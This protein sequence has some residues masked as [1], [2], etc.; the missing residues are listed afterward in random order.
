SLQSSRF[1]KVIRARNERGAVVVKLFVKQDN[2]V[3]YTKYIRR[4]RDINSRLKGVHNA[5]GFE[6]VID[7]DRLVAVVRQYH[8]SSLY[9]RISTR[10]FLS[11][12]EK[13]WISF[14]L[15]AGLADAHALGV[16]HGDIKTENVLVT[17]WCWALLAD[18][19]SFKPTFLPQD[20]PAAFAFFFDTSGRRTCCVAPERFY[21]PQTDKQT[22]AA[23]LVSETDEFREGDLTPAMDI[24]SLGCV[25]AELF[26]ESHALFSFAQLLA[27]RKGEYDITDTLNRIR[28]PEVRNLVAHMVQ[29]DPTKR[30]SA[31]ACLKLWR[32][33]AF[34]EQF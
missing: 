1:V 10:P 3:S 25:I 20:N 6:R 31:R 24:F 15:L 4:I 23:V 16:C 29:L 14:Q 33:K 12:V 19:A 30:S 32:G 2:T 5:Q 28:D 21:N 22:I 26:T 13:Q 7:T 17:S 18:F 8:F 34:P 27:Y 11:Y 9:D